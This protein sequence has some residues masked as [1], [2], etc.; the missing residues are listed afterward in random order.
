MRSASTVLFSEK[1]RQPGGRSEMRMTAGDELPR[2]PPTAIAYECVQEGL[3]ARSRPPIISTEF[4]LRR[5]R[6][7]TNMHSASLIASR[8]VR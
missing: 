4:F 7:W 8:V 5:R 2:M 1:W 6:R 3:I